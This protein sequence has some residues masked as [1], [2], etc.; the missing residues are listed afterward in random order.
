MS[1]V[2]KRIGLVVLDNTGTRD[3]KLLKAPFKHILKSRAN[4]EGGSNYRRPIGVEDVYDTGVTNEVYLY[5]RQNYYNTNFEFAKTDSKL[6]PK[7][8]FS[9]ILRLKLV[10]NW[11]K[12]L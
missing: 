10:K 12:T 1:D 8:L 7:V 11:H 5:I 3:P 6:S 9:L 4:Y 2:F